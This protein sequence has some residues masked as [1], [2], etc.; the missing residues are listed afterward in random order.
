MFNTMNDVYDELENCYNEIIYKKVKE[1]GE[2]LYIE[3]FFF[4]T[5]SDLLDEKAQ[6]RIKEYSYCKAFNCPPFPS[7]KET[8]AKVV[9]E[10]MLIEN[11]L[12]YLKSKDINGNK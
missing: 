12:N 9:D 1:V 6:Q 10:F 7:L 4:C 8:P 3:H 2:T 5:T 11:E